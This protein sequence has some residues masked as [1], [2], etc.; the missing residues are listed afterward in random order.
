MYPLRPTLPEPPAYP[1]KCSEDHD[2]LSKASA[3]PICP[4]RIEHR[5]DRPPMRRD[6]RGRRHSP[7]PRAVQPASV[8]AESCRGPFFL[9]LPR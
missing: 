6:R 1:W 5:I 2:C 8:E 7:L 4:H 9:Q 3:C